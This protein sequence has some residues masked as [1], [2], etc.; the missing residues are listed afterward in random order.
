MQLRVSQAAKGDRRMSKWTCSH[1]NSINPN[2]AFK[3][4][5]CPNTCGDEEINISEE[6]KRELTINHFQ[7]SVSRYPCTQCEAHAQAAE[8][9]KEKLRIAV[10]EFEA[11]FNFSY[12]CISNDWGLLAIEEMP[13][14]I[15]KAREVL[16]RL[17]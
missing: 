2:G 13:I 11:L 6:R 5:N 14:E 10:S 12:T 1:C 9:Y 7:A 15:R 16:E 8:E 3:C 4:H 17:R